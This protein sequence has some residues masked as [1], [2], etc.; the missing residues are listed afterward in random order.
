[1][2]LV[3]PVFPLEGCPQT[4]QSS[5]GFAQ[6]QARDRRMPSCWQLGNGKEGERNQY[7]RMVRDWITATSNERSSGE[8]GFIGF[9]SESRGKRE[10]NNRGGFPPSKSLSLYI[11]KKLRAGETKHGPWFRCLDH[12]SGRV[13]NHHCC[14]CWIVTV[15]CCEDCSKRDQQRMF[16]QSGF[17]REPLRRQL[18]RMQGAPYNNTLTQ[19]G[20]GPRPRSQEPTPT[21]PLWPNSTVR[22]PSGS[23]REG[24][25]VKLAAPPNRY[26][27]R[28]VNSGL[29]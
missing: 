19:L 18:A 5:C 22:G 7:L 6:A 15:V 28:A 9:N 16:H 21:A 26:G 24:V 23:S 25:N 13:P 2:L 17:D 14:S 1:M 29:E 4:A 3:L 11:R 10:E 8:R 20:T 12:S 27:G